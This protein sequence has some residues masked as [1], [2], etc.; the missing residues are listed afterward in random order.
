MI[1]LDSVSFRYPSS[2]QK[3]LDD[4]SL[5]VDDGEWIA[6]VGGNASGKSTLARIISGLIE[7]DEGS[8]LVDGRAAA[9][10]LRDFSG[11]PP[12][13]LTFQNPD[14]YFITASV[15]DEILFGIENISVPGTELE[16]R[17][18]EAVE[19][20]NL[21]SITS[22][23]P[24]N[25]SGGEKQ[26]LALASAWAVG[27]RYVILDEPFSFLD[28][29]SRESLLESLEVAFT[30]GNTGIIWMTLEEAEFPRADRVMYLENGKLLDRRTVLDGRSDSSPTG[31]V[32]SLDEENVPHSGGEAGKRLVEVKDAV[33]S[34]GRDAFSLN[35]PNL[36]IHEGECLGVTGL[37]GSGK[38]TLLMGCSGLLPPA[39]GMVRVLGDEIKGRKDFPYGKV[40]FVF[41]VPE[42][43]F[44]KPTVFEEVSFG[45]E[46]L[47]KAG[48]V[49]EC[50]YQA[51]S[52]A[53]L[54]PDRY[55][56]RNPYSLSQSE[57]RLVA[58]ASILAL[59]ASVY[60]FDEPL[61]FLDSTA[62]RRV[63]ELIDKLKRNGKGVVIASHDVE[64]IKKT[65]DR[66]VTCSGGTVR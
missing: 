5:K 38:S 43:S 61:I 15:R 27:A 65:A 9:D 24:H 37:N 31:V 11:A 20:F 56:D 2:N 53:G 34:Y 47:K 4:V 32:Y 6:V 42:R 19:L 44:F 33:F 58:I 57:R 29:R 21:S 14:N 22:R 45:I 46:N 12:F 59:D 30:K 39:W 62:K 60:F 26:R 55:S 23:N 13:A 63:I 66:V 8:V 10:A 17:Y 64:F 25:L 16:K 50:V 28:S 18:K 40:G 35:V 41:Q 1:V 49:W 48:S 7:P 36:S 54:D 3:V 52:A 51:L